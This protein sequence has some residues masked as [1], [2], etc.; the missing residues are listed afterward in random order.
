MRRRKCIYTIPSHTS[1]VSQLRF[2]SKS[3]FFRSISCASILSLSLSLSRSLSLALSL[4]HSSSLSP[5]LSDQEMHLRLTKYSVQRQQA[6]TKI[7][8]ILL[9]STHQTS[10]SSSTSKSHICRHLLDQLQSIETQW[11][12]TAN[13]L[14][15]MSQ[16]EPILIKQMLRNIARE[17]KVLTP[18]SECEVTELTLE[19]V[20]KSCEL[21]EVFLYS[22]CIQYNFS[23]CAQA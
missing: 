13:E 17:L 2:E 16:I 14:A 20:Q 7:R 23:V 18:S 19:S 21:Y 1:L 11:V 12:N 6:A 9:A 5:S 10:T 4:S 22:T 3:F 8:T 15:S